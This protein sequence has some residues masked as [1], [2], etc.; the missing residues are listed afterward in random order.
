MT[1]NIIWLF[2][3]VFLGYTF[4]KYVFDVPT[5]LKK[6]TEARFHHN[7]WKAIK[8]AFLQVKS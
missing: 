3:I 5:F 1:D 4:S 7:I 8:I 2:I 6:Y